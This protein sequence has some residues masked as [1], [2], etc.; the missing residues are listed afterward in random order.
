VPLA[1]ARLLFRTLSRR[2]VIL[3]LAVV[4]ANLVDVFGT[5]RNVAHGA[6]ELNPLMEGLLGAGAVPFLLT[7]HALACVGVVS[8]LLQ[9]ELPLARLAWK[10]I[11][12]LYLGIAAYQGLLWSTIP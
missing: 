2:Q 11:V 7:K 1:G 9:P 6:R 10:G 8:M 5:L 12:P 4:L 3:A